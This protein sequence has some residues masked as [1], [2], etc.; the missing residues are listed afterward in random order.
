MAAIVISVPTPHEVMELVGLHNVVDLA[1][2]MISL[3]TR[4]NSDE[5][6]VPPVV[7]AG[8]HPEACR[9]GIYLVVLQ[10]LHKHG[11]SGL[12]LDRLLECALPADGLR[13]PAWGCLC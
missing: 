11:N 9:G 1:H 7:M 8:T 4:A 13:A 2:P 10:P 3:N 12:H 5:Q 6:D